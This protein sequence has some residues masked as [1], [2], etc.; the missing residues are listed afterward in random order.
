[1]LCPEV[2]VSYEHHAVDGDFVAELADFFVGHDEDG[3][4]LA[5]FGFAG[6]EFEQEETE[7]AEISSS[8]CSC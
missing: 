4:V 6:P 7:G 2:P 8:V 3:F 5:Q 1:M